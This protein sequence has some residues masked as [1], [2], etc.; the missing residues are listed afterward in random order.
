MGNLNTEKFFYVSFPTREEN[1]PWNSN[2]I[3]ERVSNYVVKTV[4]GRVY[5]L[6]GKMKLDAAS[7]KSCLLVEKNIKNTLKKVL[8]IS[9]CKL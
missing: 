8:H 7:G 5:I 3:V 2:V 4:S 1:I 9:L 6:V